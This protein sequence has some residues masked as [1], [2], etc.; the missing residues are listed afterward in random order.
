MAMPEPGS[1]AHR[2]LTGTLAVRED[3]SEPRHVLAGYT[4][5]PGTLL[6]VR[7]TPTTSEPT[8]PEPD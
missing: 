3:G 1:V 7:P 8:G 6:E 5:L 4:V 2:A